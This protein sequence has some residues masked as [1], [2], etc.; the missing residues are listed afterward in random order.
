M[1]S[2]SVDV[3]ASKS[4]SRKSQVVVKAA[5]G[6]TFGFTTDTWWVTEVVSPP[7]S[8]TVSVTS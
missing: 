7:S 1:P 8:V 4:Q 6:G 5:V 2:L 3:V